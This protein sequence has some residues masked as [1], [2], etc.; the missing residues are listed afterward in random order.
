MAV[1]TFL[2]AWR[3]LKG[4]NSS[5]LKGV[6]IAIH[7]VRQLWRI[8]FAVILV[9][10]ASQRFGEFLSQCVASQNGP[11]SEMANRWENREADGLFLM[12]VIP[13][14]YKVHNEFRASKRVTGCV[15]WRAPNTCTPYTF[16]RTAKKL[17]AWLCLFWSVCW[18]FVCSDFFFFFSS[19]FFLSERWESAL[20]LQLAWQLRNSF[21]FSILDELLNRFSGAVSGVCQLPLISRQITV[22]MLS[23]QLFI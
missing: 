11:F 13:G 4:T 17:N 18:P 23:S 6:R 15:K 2:R 21:L 12:N 5:L 3:T 14:Q 1:F 19:S 20:K 10:M 9:G 8:W 7:I 16:R 22:Q